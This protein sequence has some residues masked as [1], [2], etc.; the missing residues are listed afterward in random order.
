M[1]RLA[2]AIAFVSSVAGSLTERLFTL[3]I[4]VPV[5]QSL[6]DAQREI[7][8]A[9]VDYWFPA[10][11]IYLA[12]R[13]VPYAQRLI[14]TRGQATAL[15][16]AN[17]VFT[18]YVSAKIVAST[19]EGGGASYAVASLSIFTAWPAAI[20]MSVVI[21]KVAVQSFRGTPK[22]GTLL[23]P[24]G[25][26]SPRSIVVFLLVGL[27]PVAAGVA[28]LMVGEDSPLQRSRTA[29]QRMQELCKTAGEMIGQ[30]PQDVQGLY[31]DEDWT[32]SF[33]KIEAGIYGPNTSG[34]TGEPF[35]NQG[36]LRFYETPTRTE[37]RQVGIKPLHY[38]RYDLQQKK[39]IVTDLIAEYG[40]FR[41]KLTM[42]EDDRLKTQ[43]YELT[44][45]KLSTGEIIA[46][47]RFF[48]NRLTRQICGQQNALKSIDENDFIRRALGLEGKSF[49]SPA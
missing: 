12:L 35:V 15:L 10:A 48:Y 24:N 47:H 20:V 31:L 17:I 25:F 11:L 7:V 13:T 42:D 5:L 14:L 18:L 40:V 4:L 34:L 19:V 3:L 6:P 23:A 46:T 21:V 39:K 27:A 32:L 16:V 30:V 26:S 2:L 9:L 43:G 22:I 36:M 8:R 38:E 44:I 29:Q 1:V 37:P 33:L 49:E 41:T 45:K 28:T